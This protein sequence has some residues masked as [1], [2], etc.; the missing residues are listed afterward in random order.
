[1]SD[2]DV[3][4]CGLS[5]QAPKLEVPA[6]LTLETECQGRPENCTEDAMCFP[7]VAR[8]RAGKPA[9]EYQPVGDGG[10]LQAPLSEGDRMLAFIE[11]VIKAERERWM[12]VWN[13]DLVRG[14][15]GSRALDELGYAI[16]AAL[17][18]FRKGS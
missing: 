3:P 17:P 5:T 16:Q 6:T 10:P 9:V 4:C 12:E 13:Y 11:G 2:D 1:M 15:H 14:Y 8:A 7:C 18:A